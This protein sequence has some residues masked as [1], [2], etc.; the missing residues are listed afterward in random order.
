MNTNVGINRQSVKL[1]RDDELIAMW[2]DRDSSLSPR[3][4][5]MI[6]DE[7]HKRGILGS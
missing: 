3:A 7:L 6:C 2:L 5:L 4:Q 1:I